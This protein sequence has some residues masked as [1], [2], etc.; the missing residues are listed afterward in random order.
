[1][2]NTLR[3]GL[4]MKFSLPRW[5]RWFKMPSPKK[6]WKKTIKTDL[7]KGAKYIGAGMLL[8][9]GAKSISHLVNRDHKLGDNSKVVTLEDWGPSL[10]RVDSMDASTEG[11]S[12][13]PASLMMFIVI[14]CVV[15]III[16]IPIIRLLSSLTRHCGLTKIFK[17]QSQ[18]CETFLPSNP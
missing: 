14:A 13:F 17:S 15:T 3:R 2:Q 8:S 5:P 12:R 6:G 18:I 16:C 4:D 9:A 1:M 10:L 7:K 11:K